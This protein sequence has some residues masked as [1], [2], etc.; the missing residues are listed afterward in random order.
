MRIRPRAASTMKAGTNT[1]NQR[2]AQ[3]NLP[4]ATPPSVPL[5]VGVL[6]EH[7]SQA[8]QAW[9]ISSQGQ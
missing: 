1:A 2:A 9:T 8:L 4:A 6:G 5:G 7:C 3:T